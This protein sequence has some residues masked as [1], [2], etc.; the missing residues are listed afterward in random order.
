MMTY[1][2]SGLFFVRD[3]MEKM[4]PDA[5]ARL[6]ERLQ[7]EDRELMRTAPAIDWIAVERV[8]RVF[9]AAA[10]LSFP[11]EGAALR[12]FG[13]AQCKHD[14]TGIYRTLPT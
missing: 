3:H 4:G 5:R 14:L 11:G 2:G 12:L 10:A 1:K 9:R 13:R 7:P 8:D 6:D